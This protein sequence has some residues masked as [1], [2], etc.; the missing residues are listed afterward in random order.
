MHS[1]YDFLSNNSDSAVIIIDMMDEFCSPG[2]WADLNN[3][4]YT[5]CNKC[6]NPINLLISSARQKNIPIIWLNWGLYGLQ[7]LPK[8]QFYLWKK[9]KSDI[10]LE[11]DYFKADQKT[12]KSFPI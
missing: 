10:G 2:G 4:D 3:L 8:N 6:I 9:K 5:Y 1:F 12:F 11:L 7:N